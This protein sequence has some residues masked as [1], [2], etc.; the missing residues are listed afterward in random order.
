MNVEIL[1]ASAGTG[2]TWRLSR[3]LARALLDG[4]A[5]PEGVVAITYTTRAAAELESRIRSVLLEAGK[6]DLAAR[7]RDGYL[8]TIHSVC[9][10][11][12]G[13]FA[14]EAGL[15]PYLEPIPDSERR[16]LF[17][18]ALSQVLAGEE[19]RLNELSHRL[20]VEDWKEALRRIVE[21]ARENGMDGPALER[22]AAES[23][24]TLDAFLPPVAIGAADYQSRFRG[25]VGRLLPA[26]R[27]EVAADRDN[28]A[29]RRRERA[30]S[31]LAAALRRPGLPP[32]KDQVQ[33][34]AL[35]DLRKLARAAGRFVTLVRS[36]TGSEGFQADLREAQARL[37]AL[38]ARAL[39][40]FAAEK[41]AARVVDFGDMLAFARDLLESAAVGQA[42][43]ARL[44]LVVVDEF[45]DTSP[46]Q[47]AVAA[48]L[49]RL[50][51]RSIWVG[52]RK[53][54]IFAF[55]GSDPELM[56][57]AIEVVLQGRPPEILSRSYRS[58]PALVDMVSE[59]FSGAFASHG[60][61]EDQVRLVAEHP[62]PPSLAG[63]PG[64]ETWR[65]A[66]E[67]RERDGAR[68]E[69][70]EPDAVAAGVAELLADPPV[71][72]ERVPGGPDRLRPA[73]RRDVAVLAFT[74][75]RCREIA[76]ALR[77]R[78]IPATVA[79]SGLPGE[80][81]FLLARAAL[82]L[83]AD[84]ADG[85]AAMEVSWLG[86]GG[87]GDPDG[88]LARRLVEVA[89]W[90]RARE[91]AAR[92]GE[93]GPARPLPFAS[94]PRVAALRAARAARLSPAEALDRAL[95]AAG[96]PELLRAWPD[97]ARRLANLESVRAEA[98]AYE[99]LCRARRTGGTAL[100]LVAHLAE[101]GD[102]AGQATPAAEDAVDVTTWH[103]AKGLEWPVVVLSQLDH[104]RE[105]DA[106]EVAVEPA[107]RFDLASPLAG[108]WIRYWPWPYAGLSKE[109][110]LLDA[111]LRSP[112]AERARGR[113]RRERLRILY[114]GFTR[115]RDLLVAVA[116]VDPRKG[117]AAGALG[118]L[119]D[120][121]GKPRVG[122]PFGEPA[123]AAAVRVGKRTWPCR[124]RSL[125][126]LPPGPPPASA[127]AVRWT[128][129]GA[130]RARPLERLNPS[131]EPGGAARL[132][133]VTPLLGRRELSA[134]SEDMGR[135]GDAVH[136]FLAADRGGGAEARRAVAAR[137]LAAH[138]VEG[139]IDAGAL[140]EASDALRSWLAA[141][142]PGAT[143]RREWP[144][145]ARLDGSDP[146][147]VVGEVDLL[148]ELPDGFALVDHKSFPGGEAER[149]RR[150]AEEWGPQLGWYA[151][152][153]SKAL[154]KP[155]RA[156]YV[157]L[158]IR[159]E[160]AEVELS[161]AVA[162]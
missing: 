133:A 160:M 152:V 38:A 21:Q 71:I 130:R 143:W 82:A 108:R 29:A 5:R 129:A 154:S 149:D 89:D 110:E 70:S 109:L 34:A 153:L 44:D 47:L 39:R 19:S 49:G 77:A 42:L 31:A 118:A 81:E 150:I 67:E 101:L 78:G 35:L 161:P 20:S 126:G 51:K 106:F 123:G 144:V 114:V 112:E 22:S 124:V 76:A 37:F 23:R 9:Q 33:A 115:A 83:L 27:E 75:D 17:D 92:A 91:A 136:A 24:R 120:E 54:A 157:H 69:A 1:S 59:L 13:E 116:R 63:Q 137:L 138:G 2:K 57:A 162:P 141:R 14:L 8:G 32:W 41:A 132:V 4:A 93:R 88:W 121:R 25:E 107:P 15:S 18:R 28:A 146:R 40:A 85:V 147:L 62:D 151:A 134:K 158:P 96:I 64:F 50:A 61:P 122:L 60:F 128:Q 45:Q 7:V 104:G 90:G 125:S 68:I 139:A 105:P 145:R 155:L 86:G 127:A 102:D 84:P 111:A 16:H 100:G 79:L 73:S 140:L 95:Y 30:A 56:S 43:R 3:D 46:L 148:L 94:D 58:R 99:D 36:H 135:V 55:Q 119:S 131:S 72:R 103:G 11:L 52:D 48:A 98:R 53:Q 87:A 12:L 65:W 156:A 159:G 74:N 66:P 97:P 113:H 142:H 10:R 26:V 6:H 80:P 117:P